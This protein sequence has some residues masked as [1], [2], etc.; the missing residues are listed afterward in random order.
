MERRHEKMV[1]TC[2]NELQTAVCVFCGKAIA[3]QDLACY[4]C[5]SG[6]D[7]ENLQEHSYNKMNN[8]KT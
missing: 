7:F 2:E 4:E 3:P 6:T 5:C 1:E 8:N